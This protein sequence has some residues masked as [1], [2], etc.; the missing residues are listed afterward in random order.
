MYNALGAVLTERPKG[1]LLLFNIQCLQEGRLGI[2]GGS[3][4]CMC[5]CTCVCVHVCVCVYVCVCV[6]VCVYMCVCACVCVC[7]CVCVVASGDMLTALYIECVTP[8]EDRPVKI[9]RLD[10]EGKLARG[11]GRGTGP[12]VIGT[13]LT[14]GSSRGCGRCSKLLE[15]GFYQCT[16]CKESYRLAMT[17]QQLPGTNPGTAAYFEVE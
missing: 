5:V 1:H 4:V 9:R 8:A 16:S 10:S 7:V 17:P 15:K 3:C 13:C 2:G 12:Y 11:G 6:C 14:P